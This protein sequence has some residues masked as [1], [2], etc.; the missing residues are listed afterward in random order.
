MVDFRPRIYPLRRHQDATP[1]PKMQPGTIS[2]DSQKMFDSCVAVS[3]MRRS[4]GS[5]GRIEIRLSCCDSQPIVFM[6]RSRLPGTP[7]VPFDAK[8]ESPI[9]ARRVS[10]F[11]AS[12]SPGLGGVAGATAADTAEPSAI[13]PFLSPLPS[14]SDTAPLV[15]NDFRSVSAQL[16][17]P[18]SMNG[19][20]VWPLTP[21]V[22]GDASRASGKAVII[23]NRCVI[24]CAGY[25]GATTGTDAS[26]PIIRPMPL[27]S[28]TMLLPA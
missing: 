1:A 20:A 12:A 17:G 13:G 4:S 7:S 23:P 26:V 3:V 21:P 16:R 14:S 19:C 11:G 18:V 9:T 2:N 15:I 28:T 8:S 5:F 25:G 6:N 22:T 27:T 24:A 10:G